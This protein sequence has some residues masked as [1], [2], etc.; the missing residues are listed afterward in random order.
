VAEAPD[1]EAIL[2]VD[3]DGPVAI[4]Q[5]HEGAELKPIVGFRS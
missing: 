5:P 2:L 3:D 1:A 4:A